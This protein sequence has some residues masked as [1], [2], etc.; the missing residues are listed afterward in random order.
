Q[1]R[2]VGYEGKRASGAVRIGGTRSELS[3]PMTGRVVR[4][5]AAAIEQIIATANWK[6]S[7]R[8]TPVS[9]PAALYTITMVAATTTVCSGVAP[10]ITPAILI[11]ASVTAAMVSTLKMTPRYAARKPRRKAAS[12]PE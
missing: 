7:V 10:I 4:N 12:L 9:P 8:R 6:R 1:H 5:Q 3:P 2:G 11:A